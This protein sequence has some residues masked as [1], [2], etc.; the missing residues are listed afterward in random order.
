MIGK[1]DTE[2][3]MQFAFVPSGGRTNSSCRGNHPFN[4]VCKFAI[5]DVGKVKNVVQVFVI[6]LFATE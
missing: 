1:L 2:F 5:T 6:V 3:L 4:Q